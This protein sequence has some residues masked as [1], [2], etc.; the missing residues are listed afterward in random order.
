[1]ARKTTFTI[2]EDL[3]K[4]IRLRR[5]GKF[6]QFVDTFHAVDLADGALVGVVGDGANGAYEWFVWRDGKLLTSEAGYGEIDVA[7]RD[8]LVREVH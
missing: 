4:V 5:S 7:L 1:M 6:T 2:P 8:V 3:A